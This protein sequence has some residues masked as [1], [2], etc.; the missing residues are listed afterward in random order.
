MVKSALPNYITT[1]TDYAFTLF[2]RQRY[3]EAEQMFDEALLV[4]PVS[5]KSLIC[6]ARASSRNGN[7][8]KA[9]YYH[10]MSFAVAGQSHMAHVRY[11]EFLKYNGDYEEA[12][13][14]WLKSDEIRPNSD[15]THYGIAMT[16]LAM[17]IQT[18]SRSTWPSH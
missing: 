18:T 16:Y 7:P 2:G 13:H 11:A 5:V 10:R 12:L 14:H 1:C 17:R 8:D 6:C 9:E 4:N 15:K 3:D